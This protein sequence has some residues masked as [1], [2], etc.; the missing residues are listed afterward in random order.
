MLYA[1]KEDVQDLKNMTL[2]WS[3]EREGWISV[4]DHVKK[5][6][7]HRHTIAIVRTTKGKTLGHYSSRKWQTGGRQE[8]TGG[9]T[10]LFYFDQDQIRKCPQ[11]EDKAWVVCDSPCYGLVGGNDKNS[12]V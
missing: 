11:I 3:T 5:C 2:L 10:F 1:V 6:A 4:D 12:Y 8:V 9:K 7:N